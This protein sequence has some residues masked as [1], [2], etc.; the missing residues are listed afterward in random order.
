MSAVIIWGTAVAIYVV[1]YLW[2][3]GLPGRVSQAEIDA[4]S[5]RI[6][7]RDLTPEER[8]RLEGVRRFFEEDNGRDFVMVNL[9]TFNE[10]RGESRRSLNSY[11]RAFLGALLKSGGHPL[12]VAWRAGGN[13]ENWGIDNVGD[14]HMAAMI[15]YRSRRAMLKALSGDAFQENHHH[16][17]NALLKTFAFPASPYAVIGGGPKLFVPVLLVAIAALTHLNFV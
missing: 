13:V 1:F 16:K 14:W 2:Y 12:A 17:V 9:L 8:E 5:A 4:F 10:P 15:R 6:D 11:Q 7:A 3:H